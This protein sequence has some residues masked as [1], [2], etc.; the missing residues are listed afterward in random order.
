MRLAA[1]AIVVAARVANA[2]APRRVD[3]VTPIGV[4]IGG[5]ALS[6]GRDPEGKSAVGAGVEAVWPGE[7]S[8]RTRVPVAGKG[9]SWCRSRSGAPKTCHA[10]RIGSDASPKTVASWA[11]RNANPRTRAVPRRVQPQVAVVE[12]VDHAVGRRR[13]ELF[14]PAQRHLGAAGPSRRSAG[15]TRH[16]PATTGNPRAH[17]ARRRTATFFIDPA[18]RSRTGIRLAPGAPGNQAGLDRDC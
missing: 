18:A 1:N 12:V 3:V 11:S 15:A 7:G 13:R 6:S 16:S 14:G 9:G 10:R 5:T 17:N 4:S 2:G 8:I